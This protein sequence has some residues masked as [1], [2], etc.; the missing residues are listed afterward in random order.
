MRGDTTEYVPLL[1]GRIGGMEVVVE[2]YDTYPAN[3]TVEG[4]PV[5]VCIYISLV[6]PRPGVRRYPA[7]RT[8]GDSVVSAAPPDHFFS[9]RVPD[10]I[11]WF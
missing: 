4:V 9:S 5:Y 11:S 3:T 6:F 10:L 7:Y 8:D 1:A 2:A